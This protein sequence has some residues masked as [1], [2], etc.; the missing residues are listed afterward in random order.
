VDICN[1]LDG[2]PLALELRRRVRTMSARRYTAC[3][4]SIGFACWPA[5]SRTTAP[6]GKNSLR[7]S[8]DWSYD[9]LTPPERVMLRP[10]PCSPADGRSKLPKRWCPA[11]SS[12]RA[13]YWIC[14]SKLVEKS[15]V[16]MEAG[17]ERYRPAR[18]GP[19]IRTGEARRIGRR[20]RRA[21]PAPRIFSRSRGQGEAGTHQS[22][23]G[24]W[25]ARLDIERE[26]L[27]T[28]HAWCDHV[29]EERE[30]GLKPA[31]LIKPSRVR[32][33]P[34]RTRQRLTLEA[35]ARPARAR[36]APHPATAWATW[37]R[38]TISSTSKDAL[39][40]LGEPG[41]CARARR[42][43]DGRGCP[44]AARSRRPGQRRSGGSP[45]LPRR[46]TLLATDLGDRRELLAALNALAQLHR[47]DGALDAAEP[48]Y[49]RMLAL[50]REL[51]DSNT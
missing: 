6:D 23:A 3:A 26:N 45:R 13:A 9:L 34:Y 2:I 27:L 38:S 20:S 10:S 11:A 33:R 49:E 43:A 30:F 48:L 42:Q 18:N 44:S 1:Q 47:A 16:D 32:A 31:H 8:I 46:G 25:L 36:R 39:D 12:N 4:W 5:A 14:M 19:P 21:Q 35:L 28:S 50:A 29:D 24:Q 41:D 17:G 15:L 22:G 7:A 51:G 37:A 40:H